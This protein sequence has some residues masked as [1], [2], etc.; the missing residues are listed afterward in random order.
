[1][2]VE[3]NRGEWFLSGTMAAFTGAPPHG[4]V[5]RFDPETLE[6]LASSPELPCGEHA[7]CGAILAHANGALFNINGSYLHRLDSDCDVTGEL[8]LP[9]DEAHNGLLALSDGTLVTK[10][11]RL[12]RAGRSTLTRIDPDSLEVIDTLTLPEGSMG[13]IAADRTDEGEI[14]Y[15][16]GTQHLWR[17]HVDGS[18]W[19][20]DEGWRPSYRA[21]DHGLAWD[22]CLSDG[23]AWVMDNGDIPPVRA[24]FAQQPNGRFDSVEPGTLSWRQPPD[25]NG[26]QRLVKIDLRTAEVH[27]VEP[28]EAPSGGIIAPPVHV[29]EQATTICWDSVNGGLAG[30]DDESL[31]VRW[32]LDVR[33]TMQP[34]VYPDSGE[35][36]INDFDDDNGDHLVV[37]DIASG[38]M[39]DRVNVGSR[40]ANGM[41]LTPGHDNDVFYC[42]TLTFARVQWA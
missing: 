10:N 24:I 40:V 2:V 26:R 11:L 7:W 42:S 36:V 15:I 19:S 22:S 25:W 9:V 30:V 23:A 34:V 18:S 35:L 20:V 33:A 37:V 29:P 8:A 39:L 1:M 6:P 28:F 17:I 12:E 13:R 21:P 32:S 14:V 3:R 41:F 16:P 5:E 4:W 27:S 31:E 38:E